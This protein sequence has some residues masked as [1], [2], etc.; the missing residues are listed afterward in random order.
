MPGLKDNRVMCAIQLS[1]PKAPHPYDEGELSFVKWPEDTQFYLFS[2]ED[3]KTKQDYV[4]EFCDSIADNSVVLGPDGLQ[5]TRPGV[6]QSYG[7]DKCLQENDKQQCLNYALPAPAIHGH[8]VTFGIS[9]VP[10]G[11]CPKKK[12]GYK[13]T[14]KECIDRFRNKILD[15]CRVKK[16]DGKTDADIPNGQVFRYVGGMYLGDTSKC[17]LYTVVS[18]KDAP[19][20]KWY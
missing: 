16:L 19:P 6:C 4:E 8:G 1:G 3:P 2:S 10:Y 20:N 15:G 14:R 17:L 18:V 12:K 13:I 5:D 7:S 11:D 9:W